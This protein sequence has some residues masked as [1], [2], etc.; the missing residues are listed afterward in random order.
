[1]PFIIVGCGI[2]AAIFFILF[3]EKEDFDFL[4]SL[5][6]ISFFIRLIAATFIYEYRLFNGKWEFFGDGHAY[7]YNGNAIADIWVA[8]FRNFGYISNYI[9]GV[10]GSG[11]LSFYDFWN[12]FILFFNERN[13]IS[14]AYVNSLAGS[15]AIIFIYYM[16]KQ[17]YDKKAAKIA[18]FLMAFWPS[19]FIW[20]VQ[21]FKEPIAILLIVALFWAVLKIKVKFRFYLLFA[22]I[23]LSMAL[24]EFRGVGFFIFYVVALPI[25]IVV[26]LFNKNKIVFMFISIITITAIILFINYTR[27]NLLNLIMFAPGKTENFPLLQWIYERRLERAYGNTALLTSFNISNPLSVISFISMALLTGCFGPFPWQSISFAQMAVIPEM[28]V[29]YLFIPAIFLGIKY[30]FKNKINEGSIIVIFV[31]AMMTLLA[32]IEGNLGTL[33]RHRA[34]VLPFLFILAAIGIS[35]SKI[36]KKTAI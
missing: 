9:L 1:M 32:I 29:Y 35:D 6:F 20:S 24:K 22:V 17:L 12:A 28:M 23:F 34:M 13:A 19:L 30:L 21:N 7:I 25:S 16:A 33:F 26:Q 27:H 14:L 11:T 10:S 3:V 15:F 36:T 8:G 4:F 31:I 18:A 5:F 2:L